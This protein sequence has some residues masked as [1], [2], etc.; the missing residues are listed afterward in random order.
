MNRVLLSVFAAGMLFAIGQALE[1]YKCDIGF[2]NL[3]FT[4][5]T[6]CAAGQQ[7]FSGV[8]KA[9]DF[10]DIKMKGCLN[11]AECDKVTNVEF[12]NNKTVYTMNK[13]CCATDL[14]NG[15]PGLPVVTPLSLTLAS[16]TGLLVVTG[17]L[18]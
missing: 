11:T 15:S 6:T 8:G 1:C 9:A 14:C 16:A 17:V 2:W 3:C 12:F 18:V 10:V 4:T 5:K 7:C 13:T